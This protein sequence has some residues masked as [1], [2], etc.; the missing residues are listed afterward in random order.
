MRFA[1]FL[2]AAVTAHG[3]TGFDCGTPAEVQTF[4]RELRSNQTLTPQQV[5]Q[6]LERL[7]A[8]YPRVYELRDSYLRQLRLSD[9][10]AWLTLRAK[11]LREAETQ[12]RDLLALTVAAMALVRSDTPQA[13]RLL[14]RAQAAG[15]GDPI[16][17]LLLAQIYQTGRFSDQ[18]KAQH[19]FDIYAEG[20]PGFIESPVDR[21]MARAASP[22]TQARMA[23]ALRQRLERSEE[24]E[25]VPAYETLWG[26]E[27]RTRAPADHAA[28]R[29]QVA[30]DLARIERLFPA[31]D[32]KILEVL[33][34]G[35]RQ[36]GLPKEEIMKFNDRIRRLAPRSS[37]AYKLAWE[38]WRQQHKEPEN[39]ADT[40]A[41]T[42]WKRAY[43]S[44]LSEWKDQYPELRFLEENWLS[45]GA[46]LKLL[47]ERQV[48][49]LL[50]RR[51]ADGERR[52]HL[53][54]LWTYL[55][56]ANMLLDNRWNP[57][58]ALPW[59]ERA[60]REAVRL[61][62]FE[63]D[64]T[65]SEQDRRKRLESGGYRS[66]VASVWLRAAQAAGQR[67]V[68]RYLREWVERPAPADRKLLPR[69]YTMRARLAA[70]EGR[71]AD[72]LAWFQQALHERD[73]PPEMFR[74]RKDDPLLEDARA[75][76]L[77]SGGSEEAFALWAARRGARTEERADGRWEKPSKALP[78][79]ELPDLSGRTWKLAELEGKAV[80][81]NL[82]ATWC[83]PCR[84]ELPLLQKLYERTKDRTDVQVITFNIDEEA[85]L[86][87][88]FVKENGFTFPVLLAYDFVNRLLD[89]IG[90]P[91]NWLL[92]SKGMWIATQLGL[93]STDSDWVNT[94][95]GKLEAARQSG[96]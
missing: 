87:A 45:L 85:G 76:F 51:I 40:E 64:D 27:F 73:K 44:A 72:A 18:E 68:P 39:H 42:Q 11:L 25:D 31:P 57:G 3:G 17:A 38:D 60:W 78:P 15:P 28:V 1:V 46:E 29:Q 33:R 91:Q 37:A 30:R 43:F 59:M 52:Q 63:E 4:L 5:R 90:I 66:Q 77:S 53:N 79:F 65:L 56:S 23:L 86:V 10:E 41:W 93:D 35:A 54:L 82:W 48:A 14:E 50:A 47:P 83:G 32:A 49:T 20:C 89:V 74:G 84:A 12:P 7:V 71:A 22:E 8:R 36:A 69:Y 24:P 80:L 34:N 75:Y 92:D 26:L 81:I 58:L 67:A 55:S 61:D 16:S 88:P 70:I 95:L 2:C 21:I 96:Q 62:E 19:Y 9:R 13:I 94:M 6:E